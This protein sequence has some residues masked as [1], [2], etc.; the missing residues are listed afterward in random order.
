VNV[1][2]IGIASGIILLVLMT[3]IKKDS[4]YAHLGINLNRIYCPICGKKQPIVRKPNNER[5]TLYGGNTCQNCDTEMDKF[6]TEI[7]VENSDRK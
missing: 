1:F 7:K 3:F 5:Q 2:L 4:K 6:G